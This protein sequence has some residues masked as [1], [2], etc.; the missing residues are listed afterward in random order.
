MKVSRIL[1]ILMLVFLLA[2]P[3]LMSTSLV[4]AAIQMLIAALFAS[5]FNVLA[6]QGGMLSFGHSAYFG[7]GTFATIHAMNALGGEGLLP[8]PLLPLFGGLAG[9]VL[10][11][12]AGWFSTQRS[13][14]YFSMITLA[15]A[16]LLHALAPHLKGIFG[17]ESG[18][19]AMRMPAWGFTFG[20]SV[21]V[22]Y[23][24]LAWVLASLALLYFFTRTPLGRLCLGLREN[25]HR[26]PFLG[27]NV[28]A[29]RL[30][31][32]MISAIFSGVAG[33]LLALSNEAANYVIFDVNLSAQVVLNAYIGGVGAF[34]GPA[35][36]AA[37]MTFFGY[38]VSD[39]T[40]TW[41]LYQGVIFVLV[42][43]FMPAGLFSIASWWVAQRDRYAPA[44]LIRILATW[45]VG[46]LL[47]A[48]GFVIIVELSAHI[49]AQDYQ[50]LLVAGA[51]WPAVVLFGVQWQPGALLTW[52]L[53]A[54]LLIVGI[55]VVLIGNKQWDY[56]RQEQ[57]A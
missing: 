33:G 13:G 32:F 49:L 12:V 47:A 18:V 51:A 43:M 20:S 39:L 5:A 15:L 42:M 10:G 4:N 28:H 9:C 26:L 2:L 19:S 40:R 41:L 48:S 23:L 38:A 52:V 1:I 35:L 8:A 27:Y 7:I 54:I 34:F 22:Y 36:G 44:V 56:A 45:I 16:E 53:P 46:C 3:A 50:S 24:T 14:V 25:S 29:L 55:A 57:A 30:S 31:V 11:I 37:I 6:G 21:E 17:G